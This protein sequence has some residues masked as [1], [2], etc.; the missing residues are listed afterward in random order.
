[1][2]IVIAIGGNALLKKGEAQTAETLKRNCDIVAKDIAQLAIEHEIILVHGNGP[3]VGL[4]ALQSNDPFDILDAE[5]QGMIGYVLQQSLDNV[6]QNK[7]I[8]VT[9]LTQVKVDATDPA[10]SSATKP[11]GLYYNEEEKIKLEQERGWSF[12]K[13]EQQFRRV[14]PSPKPKKIVELNAIKLLAESAYVVIAAGGGGIPCV[15]AEKG[16]QGIEA[17]I[18]KDL[19]AARLALD[20]QADKL[21]IL[22]DVEGVYREWGNENQALASSAHVNELKSQDFESGSMA[23]KIQAA[24]QFA[25]SSGHSA[26]I[27]HL[28]NLLAI[29]EN[30]SGTSIFV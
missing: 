4:L 23:P 30:R 15:Q 11:I 21:I 6:L 13:R 2:R 28:E 25:E 9:V 16:L 12:V 17:V 5:S 29:V 8:A 3:Q 27:G 24:C 19:T 14:V 20:L 22:T 10:F 7:K 1:M 26:A 18:D